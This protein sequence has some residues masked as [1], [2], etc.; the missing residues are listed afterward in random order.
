MKA[1]VKLRPGVG[2]VELVDVAEPACPANGVKIDVKFTGIC[3]TDLHVFHDTFKNYPPVIL[4]HEFSGVICEKGPAVTTLKVGDRVTVL[5]SSAVVCGKCEY[6]RQG[7]Y[8]FCPIRRG[9]GHGVNGSFTRFAAVR[10][11]QCYKLPDTVSF[12]EGAMAEPFAAALQAVGEL[13]ACTVG[14]TVLLSGPGPIGL[15]CLMVLVS[16]GCKVIV[17]GTSQDGP[18]LEM[19]KSLGAAIVLDVT[20]ENLSEIIAR[21][22]G[23]RG[24]D[25]AVE[26]AGVAASVAA[27]LAAVRRLGKYFQV[28]ILGKPISIDFDTIL[29]KQIQVFGSVGHSLKTWEGVMR[30]ICSRSIDL[31]RII[32]HKLPLSRWREAFDLCES[33]KGVKVMLYYDE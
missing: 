11:D 6:C 27:C 31:T 10:E 13:S 30:I 2:H 8:M 7:Y 15:L 18:R 24:V 26:V 32:T 12:E 29:F 21:E 14:D 1:L 20:R 25:A 9:M 17:A 3:G 28:G 16:Q 19:A 22:T 5:P 23:G 33:K 4:G